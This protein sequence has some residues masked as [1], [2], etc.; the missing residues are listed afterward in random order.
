MLCVLIVMV[1]FVLWLMPLY[2][3]EE[4]ITSVFDEMF[5][6]IE[7][8]SGKHVVELKPAGVA[9]DVMEVNK[10]SSWRS[11]SQSSSARSCRSSGT[12]CCQNESLECDSASQ[13]ETSCTPFLYGHFTLIH[14]AHPSQ[15][16]SLESNNVHLE[17]RFRSRLE[18]LADAMMSLVLATLNYRDYHGIIPGGFQALNAALIRQQIST[19][20]PLRDKSWSLR[21]QRSL[22]IGC[23][24]PS[25]GPDFRGNSRRGN[26]KEVG[27]H[28][29]EAIEGA[30][31]KG[32]PYIV[33]QP[34]LPAEG[35]GR[36]NSGAVTV[37][38]QERV[39]QTLVEARLRIRRGCSGS[40]GHSGTRIRW[41]V[42]QLASPQKR[43]RR[44]GVR[45]YAGL[46]KTFGALSGQG[47]DRGSE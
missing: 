24:V 13:L 41:C 21:A 36:T 25:S 28:M 8:C 47:V 16:C 43:L 17:R 10:E 32:W 29:A 1:V 23:S 4:G 44:G 6:V 9:Q 18:D 34:P 20:G 33:Y 30:N 22:E 27:S 39:S 42:V 14:P 3:R 46:R 35:F 26:I 31:T 40:A 15:L 37:G 19:C 11:R 12:C 5:F 2:H 38:V 7:D 45:H